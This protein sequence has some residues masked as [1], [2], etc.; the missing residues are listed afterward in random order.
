MNL[1]GNTVAETVLVALVLAL[2]L[3]ARLIDKRKKRH[4]QVDY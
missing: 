4:I 3:R 2:F 1:D